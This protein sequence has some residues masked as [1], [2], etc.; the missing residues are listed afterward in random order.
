MAN[1]TI[2]VLWTL[3]RLESIL[4]EP[5]YGPYARW[6]VRQMLDRVWLDIGEDQAG[7][8][9]LRLG[10]AWFPHITRPQAS[11]GIVSRVGGRSALV[12]DFVGALFCLS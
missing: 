10:S 1:G 12:L 9:V 3:I 6:P 2:G 5:C 7:I 4:D 8:G 11:W